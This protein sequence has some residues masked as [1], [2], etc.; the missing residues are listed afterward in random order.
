MANS[1]NEAM[2]I[3]GETEQNGGLV[4]IDTGHGF[5]VWIDVFEEED[6]YEVA[7]NK[8][9]FHKDI[10]LDM[11]IQRYQESAENFDMCSSIAIDYYEKN[12]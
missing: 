9:I 8:F 2:L 3:K 1:T 4:L 10:P 11:K 6:G 7:W 12:K 5:N